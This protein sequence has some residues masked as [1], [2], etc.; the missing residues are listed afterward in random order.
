R[1]R[2]HH[3]REAIPLLAE[4]VL[5][6]VAPSLGLRAGHAEAA[7]EQVG[8]P[9]RGGGAR[10]GDDQP[11]DQELAPVTDYEAGPANHGGSPPNSTRSGP[12]APRREST[13]GGRSRAP[14]NA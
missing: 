1:R 11:R 14:R 9:G 7:G 3:Q 13:T 2:L 10:D 6:D 8:E 12:P 4:M 5:E